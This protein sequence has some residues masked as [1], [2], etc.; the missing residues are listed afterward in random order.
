MKRIVIGIAIAGVVFFIAYQFL[1]ADRRSRLKV[2][3]N[4]I[5]GR[6]SFIHS[7]ENRDYFSQRLLVREL[8]LEFKVSN[9]MRTRD[10][11]HK[12]AANFE[13]FIERETQIDTEG[14]RRYLQVIRVPSESLGKF[15]PHL[16]KLADKVEHKSGSSTD[17]TEEFIDVKSRVATKKEMEKRYQQ[18]IKQ[19][20]STKDI[21][22]IETQI[23]AVRTEIES[24]ER[25]IQYLENET[26]MATINLE[27]RETGG[28]RIV[29]GHELV[30]S[31]NDGWKGLLATTVFI[32]KV[33]PL[34]IIMSTGTWLY[35]RRKR[36]LQVVPS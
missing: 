4:K 8:S 11:V 13:G 27:F 25:R 15:V 2:D 6:A 21:L 28:S 9:A 20:A 24:M 18:L 29:F 30:T 5:P 16:E 14:A 31:L 3:V 26:S 35:F 7:R 34:L 17:V 1:F 23:G 19:A 33:W 36:K 22:E 32:I 12:L 10:S